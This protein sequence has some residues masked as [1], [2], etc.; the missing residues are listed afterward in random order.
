MDCQDRHEGRGVHFRRRRLELVE[1]LLSC[2]QRSL[3]IAA[4]PS[5]PMTA[6]H[7]AAGN[8]IESILGLHGFEQSIIGH[9]VGR[10]ERSHNNVRV[11]TANHV[12]RSL[13][14]LIAGQ[15]FQIAGRIRDRA[16]S[17]LPLRVPQQEPIFTE[18]QR[19]ESNFAAATDKGKK[20]RQQ[21]EFAWARR[22]M[23]SRGGNAAEETGGAGSA[24]STP[25]ARPM[26]PPRARP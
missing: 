16:A 3:P 17:T 5:S 10:R 11:G 12:Q 24:R 8:Q 19:Q 2:R 15:A 26:P 22:L 4:R 13:D 14:A 18:R 6:G 21:V 20:G 7:G 25:A 23:S 1:A 9:F